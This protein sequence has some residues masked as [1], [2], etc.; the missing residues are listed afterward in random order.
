MAALGNTKKVTAEAPASVGNVAVGFDVLGHAIAGLVDTVTVERVATPGV[1]VVAI[2]GTKEKLPFDAEKNTAAAAVQTMVDALELEGGFEISI[3]KGIPLSAGLGG[4]AASAVAAVVAVNQMLKIPLKIP[5]LYPFAV[6]GEAAASGGLHGDN[7]GASL[8][9]GLVVIGPEHAPTVTGLRVPGQLR[10]VLVHPH[11]KLETKMARA[12]LPKSHS[13]ELVTRQMGNL[14][15]FLAGCATK[16]I[17]L[18]GNSLR[19]VLIEPKRAGLIPGFRAAQ[20]AA[21]EAGALGC[22]I[23]GAGPTIFAWCATETAAKEAGAAIAESFAAEGLKSDV[24]SSPINCQGA[25]VV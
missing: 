21:M 9:G 7:V 19:D 22:S 2:T 1:R 3:D 23:S 14:A 17:A 8:V 10:C 24:F 16:D 15:S 4:S 5:E 25:R 13:R 20:A 11:L 6:A 18:I 12:K